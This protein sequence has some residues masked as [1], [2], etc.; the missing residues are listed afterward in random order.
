MTRQRWVCDACGKVEV[1]GPGW[2]WFG[3]YRDLEDGTDVPTWCSDQCRPAD[4]SDPAT[5]RRA[6]DAAAVTP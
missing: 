6:N 3:S 5:W 2:S 4:M 1:W